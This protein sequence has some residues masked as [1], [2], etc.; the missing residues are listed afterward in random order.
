MY[1]SKCIYYTHSF[2]DIK[3]SAAFL[4]FTMKR[5]FTLK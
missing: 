2:V 1:K 3:Y 5:A 4:S